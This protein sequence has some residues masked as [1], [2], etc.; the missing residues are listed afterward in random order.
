MASL[1]QELAA[2]EAAKKRAADRVKTAKKRE[3]DR[4]KRDDERR[5]NRV[6]K[7]VTRSIKD[8]P[9]LTLGGLGLSKSSTLP[10]LL[11]ALDE[12]AGSSVSSESSSPSTTAPAP[13]PAGDQTAFGSPAPAGDEA[14]WV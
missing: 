6:W 13:A 9:D 11:D 5:R 7:S 8:T 14:G 10:D 3:R 1:D 4:A 12:L 2:A